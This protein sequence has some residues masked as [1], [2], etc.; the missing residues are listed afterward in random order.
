MTEPGT[1]YGKN[2][3]YA[4]KVDV[5]NLLAICSL[6]THKFVPGFVRVPENFVH[7]DFKLRGG[8]RKSRNSGIKSIV[9]LLY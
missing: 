5:I 6:Y 7:F 2:D 8:G 3:S 9:N 4:Q 1:S